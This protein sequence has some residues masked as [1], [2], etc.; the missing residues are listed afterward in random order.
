MIKFVISM[1][2]MVITMFIMVITISIICMNYAKEKLENQDIS[3]L[4][5]YFIVSILM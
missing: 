4:L 3:L 2:I 1:F 5:L